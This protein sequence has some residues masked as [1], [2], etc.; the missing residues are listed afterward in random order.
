MRWA[1][2]GITWCG[3]REGPWYKRQEGMCFSQEW[4]NSPSG[5]R[6]PVLRGGHVEPR[7]V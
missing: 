4:R 5:E 1:A 6:R 7:L 2:A 3:R